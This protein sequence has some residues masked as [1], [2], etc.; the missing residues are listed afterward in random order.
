MNTQALK[1][2]RQN[3]DTFVEE[4]DDCIKTAPS[5]RH[6]R[7]Y[8]SGQVSDLERKSIEPIAL[9]AGVAPRTL[10]EFMEIHRWS[11]KQ[12]A[13]RLR[14][15]IMRDHADE[16]A[17]AVIDETGY[18]KKGDQTACVQRQY[19]GA[20]GKRDNCV[21]SVNLTYATEDFHAL[22]DSDLY[23]PEETW[24]D[25]R[26]RCRLAGIPDEVVYRPKWQI[27]LALLD[28]SL[29]DGVR[30]QYLTADELYGGCSA[31][32]AGVAERG[33]CYVV[34][35]PCNTHGW[36][37]KP[38]IVSP[39]AYSGT[40]R[41]RRKPYLA[42]GNQAACRIDKMWRRAG[43]KWE[44]FHVKDTEKGPVVWEVRTTRFYANADGFSGSELW[45]IVARNRLDGEVKY[46]LSNAPREACLEEL[47]YVAFSRW[48]IERCFEDAKGQVGLDH[49]EVRQY[50][51]L[52]RHLVLSM[53][54]L[55]FLMRETKRL[56]KKKSL[57]ESTPSAARGRSA[58]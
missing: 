44:L 42:P 43:P 45:L 35:V 10:Q 23:L 9:A 51:P 41:P 26:R 31:F 21:I 52:L 32:R 40:G 54:S 1:K 50:R 22:I 46:F 14:E 55:L 4:F 16:N 34:E 33:L 49:F 7:T 58:A 18:P 27:A 30:C 13:S 57:V 15:I 12:V 5:R 37:K 11:E 56:R 2:I 47:L 8:V 39:D 17:I 6:L 25:D 29:A 19:C 24:H 28:R 20:T 36:T 3:L 53:V 48:R 38:R